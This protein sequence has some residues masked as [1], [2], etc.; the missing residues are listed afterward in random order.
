MPADELAARWRAALPSGSV[1]AEADPATALDRA[2]AGPRG[3]VGPIIVAGSLYLV[4]EAR[5]RFVNDPDLRDPE[6]VEDE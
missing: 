2:F 4:G 5:S 6:P 1:I 3:S